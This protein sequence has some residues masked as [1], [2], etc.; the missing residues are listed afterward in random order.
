MTLVRITRLE[1]HP[2]PEELLG[3]RV[4]DPIST[5]GS[6]TYSFNVR[7]WA[8]GKEARIESFQ[9]LD[10][11][12]VAAEVPSNELRRDV[13]KAYSEVPSAEQSG[14]QMLVRAIE[15]TPSFSIEVV[16]K[17][18]GG[19]TC[20]LATIEG[21]RRPLSVDRTPALRP[22][23]LT[24]IGRSGSKWLAWLVSCHPSIIA[25]QPLVF[26]PRVTTYWATVFRALSAPK[27]YLRQIHTERW[28]EERWWLGDGA[29]ALPAP[30]EIGM[31]DWLG[32]DSVRA[33]GAICQERVEAFYLE[34][35]KR[36]DKAGVKY[37][38]EKCLLDSVLLDLTAEI[39]PGARE[40]ILVRD[41]R[42]R[43]SSVFAW[44]EKRG[45]HG[46]GHTPEMSKADY[47]TERVRRD[48]EGLLRRWRRQGDGAHLI[49]YE[50]LILEPARVLTALL[51]FLDLDAGEAVVAQML[52]TAT[53]PSDL[54]DR[55][56]TVSDPAQ[57]IGRWRHDLPSG[58][59]EECNE[60]LSPVLSEF[61]YS[62]QLEP[63]GSGH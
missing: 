12:R 9:V 10:G 5:E 2:A 37:F 58:L 48:A 1:Q 33:L 61:G 25:F 55:H 13:A 42:D 45:D 46:F 27:S 6:E 15:L 36:S 39:F 23:M 29:G 60:I 62:T 40:V 34:V 26:E 59:A 47:L 18:D 38:A 19:K 14:F 35:A 52:E 24:T 41:F 31:A 7:G 4:D 63:V 44:N 53:R 11:D 43:L 20:S 57:T 17:L 30:V 22:L 51:E 50:D 16:A 8:L 56:R 54:L 32:A 21:T 28:E 49:R 3:A